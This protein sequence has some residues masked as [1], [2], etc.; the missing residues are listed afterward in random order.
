MAI[1]EYRV[2]VKFKRN[3]PLSDSAGGYVDVYSDVD[4]DTT[5][6]PYDGDVVETWAKVQIKGVGRLSEDQTKQSRDYDL[7]IKKP[8]EYVPGKNDL[9]EIVDFTTNDAMVQGVFWDPK[10]KEY[11]IKATEWL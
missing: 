9:I 3:T 5:S 7:W 4:I 11:Q 1:G 10:N 2:R 8:P 6:Y